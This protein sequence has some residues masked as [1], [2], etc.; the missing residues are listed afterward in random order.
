MSSIGEQSKKAL[1]RSGAEISSTL[2][3]SSMRQPD[4]EALLVDLIYCAGRVV[5]L[6][7]KVSRDDFDRNEYLQLALTRLVQNVGEAAY[8]LSQ[9][10]RAEHPEVPWPEVI[11]MRHR[12]V[13]DY[14]RVNLDIVWATAMDDVPVLIPTLEQIQRQVFPQKD[15]A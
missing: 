13:H 12:L 6:T 10:F 9:G 4:D 2:R 1:T 8:Q 5:D 11:G 3:G 14:L 7:A 15:D